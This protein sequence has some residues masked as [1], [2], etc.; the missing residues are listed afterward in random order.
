MPKTSAIPILMLSVYMAASTCRPSTPPAQL[1]Q[2]LP[3]VHQNWA[4]IPFLQAIV[5]C[6]I[7][8]DL[9]VSPVQFWPGL[10]R[11][12]IPNTLAVDPVNWWFVTCSIWGSV[13]RCGHSPSSIWLDCT[14]Q[15][16]HCLAIVDH[17][18]VG[19]QSTGGHSQGSHLL[20]HTIT[21]KFNY[22]LGLM[23][24]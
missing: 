6:L 20:G 5:F 16:S 21:A 18:E 4:M 14:F 7:P 24:K 3:L 23:W 17:P 22:V 2:S 10:S 13:F 19:Y 12:I 9:H 8:V 1:F 11:M 15:K